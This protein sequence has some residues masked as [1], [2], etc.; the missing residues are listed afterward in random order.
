MAKY[1]I[2]VDGKRLE[3]ITS[4]IAPK[5]LGKFDKI[6]KRTFPNQPNVYRAYGG[7]KW[8]IEIDFSMEKIMACGYAGTVVVRNDW[9]Y[10]K[11]DNK[12]GKISEMPKILNKPIINYLNI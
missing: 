9:A 5:I 12:L 8:Y 2:I 10:D 6:T 4:N 7:P 3:V 11:N 1:N